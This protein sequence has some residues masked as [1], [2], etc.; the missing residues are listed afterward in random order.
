MLNQNSKAVQEY[1]NPKI[2]HQPE[3]EILSQLINY[4]EN[5]QKSDCLSINYINCVYIYI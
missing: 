5:M 3:C 2:N 1:F 4:K